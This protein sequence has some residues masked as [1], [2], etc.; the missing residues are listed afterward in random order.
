MGEDY[1]GSMYPVLQ[2]GNFYT[3]GPTSGRGSDML[4]GRWERP[5]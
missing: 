2:G 1:Y 3:V 4:S 5:F